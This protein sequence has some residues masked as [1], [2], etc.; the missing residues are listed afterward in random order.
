MQIS[1]WLL[2]SSAFLQTC[3]ARKTDAQK[4]IVSVSLTREN[5]SGLRELFLQKKTLGLFLSGYIMVFDFLHFVFFQVQYIHYCWKHY[6]G[7][8]RG[9]FYIFFMEF[10]N[11]K[12]NKEVGTI[13]FEVRI[14]MKKPKILME[15][16]YGSFWKKY[17][18]LDS[19]I[20][21]WKKTKI[22]MEVLL[23]RQKATEK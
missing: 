7:R 2:R 11:W 18:F 12:E 3:Y 4:V 10:I 9:N 1:R 8:L 14:P 19:T 23:Y 22:F 5:L 20:L 17:Q 13:Y 15:F 16:F 21:F 6:V